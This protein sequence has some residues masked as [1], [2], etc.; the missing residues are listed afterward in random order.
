M[1][2][3]RAIIIAVMAA[4]MIRAPEVT[5]GVCLAAIGVGALLWLFTDDPLPKAL[6]QALEDFAR[7]HRRGGR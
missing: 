2:F 5:P 4:I 6:D 7:K 3:P 1:T